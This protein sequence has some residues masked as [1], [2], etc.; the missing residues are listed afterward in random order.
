MLHLCQ[1]LTFGQLD[2]NDILDFPKLPNESINPTAVELTSGP[3]SIIQADSVLTYMGQLLLKGRN[4]NR[5]E[6]ARQLEIFPNAWK[7]YFTEVRTPAEFQPSVNCQR[8]IPDWWNEDRFG[9][10]H[11]LKLVK[12][13]IPPSY[14]SATSPANFHTVVIA[15]GDE[16]SARLGLRPPYM[17]GFTSCYVL[18]VHL[19]M[20]Q[21]LWTDTLLPF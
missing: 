1:Q 3:H 18:S 9:T 2:E 17:I 20:A 16:P 6:T 14:R 11:D 5:E 12:C 8:W 7:L 19:S 4:L 15:Y 10:F 21:S 13:K